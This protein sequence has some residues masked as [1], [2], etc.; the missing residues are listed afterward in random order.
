LIEV[1]MPRMDED[2]ERKLFGINGAR[3]YKLNL[4]PL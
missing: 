3:F 2:S 4:E 1:L